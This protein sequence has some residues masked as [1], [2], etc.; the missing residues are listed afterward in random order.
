MPE[1]WGIVFVTAGAVGAVTSTGA[2]GPGD[3][4]EHLPYHV[5]GNHH[6]SGP[7]G[8]RSL[9][10]WGPGCLCA[11]HCPTSRL[12]YVLEILPI[13]QKRLRKKKKSPGAQL[14]RCHQT[15]GIHGAS[16]N[17]LFIPSLGMLTWEGLNCQDTSKTHL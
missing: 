15:Y 6:P 2:R 11:A 17:S 4:I 1:A 10:Y 5:G 13:L 3:M 8:S 14:P 12:P 16:R 9:L 7:L